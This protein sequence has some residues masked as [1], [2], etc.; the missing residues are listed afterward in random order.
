MNT[1]SELRIIRPILF[2]MLISSVVMVGFFGYQYFQEPEKTTILGIKSV[3]SGFGEINLYDPEN[4]NLFTRRRS[5]RAARAATE[6]LARVK[7]RQG[8]VHQR[9]AAGL[10]DGTRSHACAQPARQSLLLHDVLLAAQPAFHR[11]L[12]RDQGADPCAFRVDQG[13]SKIFWRLRSLR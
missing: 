6:I 2:S 1:E 5:H 8:R 4:A 9:H 13:E 12:M 3:R 10:P 11:H 7:R